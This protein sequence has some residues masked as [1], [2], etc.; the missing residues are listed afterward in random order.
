LYVFDLFILTTKL[1]LM[2]PCYYKIIPHDPQLPPS[3]NV[4][5]EVKIFFSFYLSVPC[6]VVELLVRR[7]YGQRNVKIAIS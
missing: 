1:S 2:I 3:S 4:I 7:L 5:Y 6:S